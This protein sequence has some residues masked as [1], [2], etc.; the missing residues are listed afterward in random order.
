MAEKLH[1]NI[2]KGL[3]KKSP[4]FKGGTLVCDCVT[5]PVTVDYWIEQLH[6]LVTNHFEETRSR[7]AEAILQ[8]WESELPNFLQVCPKEML[9]NLSHPLTLEKGA[10][11]A[12]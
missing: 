10:V 2:D 3:P 9:N 7:R 1:P 4:R 8:H 12:E 11:P 6:R 5:N